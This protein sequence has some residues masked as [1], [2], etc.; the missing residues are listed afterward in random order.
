VPWGVNWLGRSKFASPWRRELPEKRRG[1]W[2]K[3]KKQNFYA[4]VVMWDGWVNPEKQHMHIV[5]HWNYE[6]G[7]KKN[8]YVIST[9]I[10]LN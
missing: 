6:P 10:K 1:R 4:H 7:V 5:G 8:I 2:T 3:I 9:S